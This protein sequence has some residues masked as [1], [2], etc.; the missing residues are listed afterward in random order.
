MRGVYGLGFGWLVASGRQPATATRRLG[1]RRMGGTVWQKFF[2]FFFLKKKR[3]LTSFFR[4]A[5]LG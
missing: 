4:S 3:L 1:R 2:C 5:A